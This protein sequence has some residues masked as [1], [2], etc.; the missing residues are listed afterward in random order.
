MRE[1][2]PPPPGGGPPAQL[3]F[4]PPRIRYAAVIAPSAANRTA[5]APPTSGT[6]EL[7]T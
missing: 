3:T 7:E 2:G 5:E 1:E 6:S 4:V